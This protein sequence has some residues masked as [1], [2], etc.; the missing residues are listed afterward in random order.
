MLD[1]H[2]KTDEISDADFSTNNKPRNI[3]VDALSKQEL[4]MDQSHQS[5]FDDSQQNSSMRFGGEPQV[6]GPATSRT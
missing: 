5:P 6:T 4:L 2:P 3:I 1:F